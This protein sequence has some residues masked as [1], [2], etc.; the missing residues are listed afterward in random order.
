VKNACVCVC[1]CVYVHIRI[2]DCVETVY[3]LPL[4]TNNTV[5]EIFLPK[6]GG[7]RSVDWIFIIRAPTWLRL[8]ECLSLD[9][10][11]NDLLFKQELAIAAVTSIISSLSLSLSNNNN[12]NN[13][14][15]LLYNYN[16]Y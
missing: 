3:E 10:T 7:V 15:P 16:I 14:V 12:N 13:N 6:S 1:V 11:F 9:E 8:G 4:L 2:S 5:S